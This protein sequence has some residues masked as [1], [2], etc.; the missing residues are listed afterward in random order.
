MTMRNGIRRSLALGALSILASANAPGQD[1]RHQWSVGLTLDGRT[2]DD[3]N[4]LTA[5]ADSSFVRVAFTYVGA[6]KPTLT[7]NTVVDAVDDGDSGVDLTEAYLAWQPVPRSPFRHSVRTGIFYPPLS[8]EN[9]GPA[10]SSPYTG[11]FSAI[12]TWVGEEL[13]TIGAEWSLRRSLGPRV[14]QREVRFIAATYY[15]ND[16]AG[17][18]LSWRGWALHRR[19]SRLDDALLLPAVPQIQSGQMF[20]K[21][22]PATEPFEETDH[23]PG[24][25]Y[26]AEWT[27][28]RRV[29]LTALRYDN[30][31]DPVSLRHGHYGW[32]TRFN[33]VG[34]QLE[35]PRELGL[36][37]QL[38][39]GTTVMG[40]VLNGAHVVDNGLESSFVLL[41]RKQKRQRW[42]LRFDDFAMT[43]HD[44]TPIDDNSESGDALTVAWR[45]EPD[46]D[47]SIGLEWRKLDITRPAFAY[48]SRPVSADETRLNLDVRYRLRKP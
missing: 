39:D 8:L 26:G 32:E 44:T 1:H 30:H 25:Y 20:G 16:P 13:R 34:A 17:A 4:K 15:G 11:S 35:L 24:F 12:N 22:A 28:G 48:F 23:R 2:T 31:A 9:V 46:Q 21:Q 19:Q 6:I 41:T 7:F 47:W 42:S 18:L 43:D 45:Y 37:M 33:H 27:L 10:W 40:P 38:I 29:R 5:A 14:R 3:T 36:I